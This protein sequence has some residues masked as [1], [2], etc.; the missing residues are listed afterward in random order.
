MKKTKKSNLIWKTTFFV[1]WIFIIPVFL[2]A[3]IFSIDLSFGLILLIF[4]VFG[5]IFNKKLYEYMVRLNVWGFEK[6]EMNETGQAVKSSAY[7]KFYRISTFLVGLLLLF[8]GI[9]DILLNFGIDLRS[10]FN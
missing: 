6:M 7:R 2:V 3:V 1:F 4:G 9:F 8:I 10:L 5:T